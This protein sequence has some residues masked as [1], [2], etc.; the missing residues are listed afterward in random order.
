[1]RILVISQFFPPDIT[2]AAFRV[3]DTVRLLAD[4]G[5]EVKVLTAFPHK[6][7]AEGAAAEPELS[8]VEVLRSTL[9]PVGPGG[10]RRYI[11]HYL[12]FVL[13]SMRQGIAVWFRRWRPDVILASSPPL[14][15]GITARFLAML[16]RR[17]LIFEVRDIWP[18]SA[19][20]AGQL[21]GSGIAY[22]IGKRL[23]LYLY[24]RADHILCVAQPMRLRIAEQTGTPV[25]VAYN[26]VSVSDVPDPA[27]EISRLGSPR[28][29]L[30]AGNLGR[31]QELDLAIQAYSELLADGKMADWNL[32]FIGA[33][34]E[35]ENLRHQVE[36]LGLGER[37]VVS[38]PVTREEAAKALRA[39]D[40]LYLSLMKDPVL[41]KTIPSKVF[42]YLLAS[43]PI[44]GGVVGEGCGILNSTGAN[45]TFEPGSLE[46]VKNALLVLEERYVELNARASK[47]RAVV[48]NSYTREK[49]VQVLLKVCE[50]VID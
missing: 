8:G 40:A 38:P 45:V 26:G 49:A 7:Q 36:E 6:A 28:T 12:S 48:L 16:F 17:P 30:Y 14:F 39:A 2:A 43:R 32:R 42:D 37:V 23:E 35:E 46:G 11:T 44:V 19:V 33:G 29:I 1:M 34:A 25:D 41:E 10:A 27:E 21:P 3:G 24:S 50:R 5:H 9:Y 4:Q 13:G 20:A 15:V 22:S 47:N 31:V 18:D